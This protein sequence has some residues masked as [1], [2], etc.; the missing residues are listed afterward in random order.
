MAAG[1]PTGMKEYIELNLAAFKAAD[2]AVTLVKK[3]TDDILNALIDI[4][5][6]TREINTSKSVKAGDTMKL[7][8]KFDRNQDNNFELDYKLGRP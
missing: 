6:I 5:K 7:Y 1:A 3:H 2:K 8:D 4:D